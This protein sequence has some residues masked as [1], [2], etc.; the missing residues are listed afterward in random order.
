MGDEEGAEGKAVPPSP[1]Q[2]DT[3]TLVAVIS[4]ITKHILA[5]QSAS[6]SN[7]E[8]GQASAS[9]ADASSDKVVD[10]FQ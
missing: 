9:P 2:P 1:L 7:Q 10:R 8:E 3:T 5:A 6:P 4:S